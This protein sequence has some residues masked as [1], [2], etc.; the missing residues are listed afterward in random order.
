MKAKAK[1]SKA[2]GEADANNTSL[3]AYR[4]GAW[5][6]WNHPLVALRRAVVGAGWKQQVEQQFSMLSPEAKKLVQLASVTND[7][8]G[9]MGAVD[10]LFRQQKF[11]KKLL[12]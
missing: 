11:P 4:T 2:S 1:A 7:S 8:D 6:E 10:I 9:F 3:A 5:K 12:S